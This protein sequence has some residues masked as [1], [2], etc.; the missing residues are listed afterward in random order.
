MRGLWWFVV[1]FE[2]GYRGVAYLFGDPRMLPDARPPSRVD[3]L[4]REN[5]RLRAEIR[6]LEID[7]KRAADMNMSGLANRNVEPLSGQ[8]AP[9]ENR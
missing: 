3:Y 4:E 1:G 9:S 6:R 7:L 2:I 5:L 8:S